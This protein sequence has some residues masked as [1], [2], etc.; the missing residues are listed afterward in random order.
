MVDAQPEVVP[1]RRVVDPLRGEAAV[2]RDLMARALEVAA[3][4]GHALQMRISVRVAEGVGR[5]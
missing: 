5:P 2:F 4:L 1:V 3:K